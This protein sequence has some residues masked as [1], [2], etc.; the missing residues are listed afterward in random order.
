MASAE[1][2]TK[3]EDLTSMS[4][5]NSMSGPILGS[6]KMILGRVVEQKVPCYRSY[7]IRQHY[8][9][10]PALKIASQGRDDDCM[11]KNPTA[12]GS[13]RPTTTQQGSLTERFES[14]TPYKREK[15]APRNY[16]GDSRVYSERCE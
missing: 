10:V 15:T 8:K 6:V 13:S 5:R 2:N 4:K 11:A 14:I 1:L 16:P 12:S 3:E 7:N 9:S